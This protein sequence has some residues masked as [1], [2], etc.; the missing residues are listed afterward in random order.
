[1]Y[2][3]EAS[4]QLWNHSTF[5][6]MPLDLLLLASFS[7]IVSRYLDAT[8]IPTIREDIWMPLVE[9]YIDTRFS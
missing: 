6:G 9:V 4:G 7:S 3:L 2:Q 8:D 5:E 1:M